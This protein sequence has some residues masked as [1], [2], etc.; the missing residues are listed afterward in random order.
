MEV[1][2]HGEQ[3]EPK[4][5]VTSSDYL[6]PNNIKVFISYSWDS[7]EHKD[8]VFFLAQALRLDGVDCVIDQF[9]QSPDNWQRWMLDQIEESDYVLIIC[10]ERYYKRYRGQEEVNKGLGVTW[11]STLI[12]GE[13]YEAQGR[14]TKFVPV[15]FSNPNLRF[16][17]DGIRNSWH[18]FSDCKPYNLLTIDDRLN[19][20]SAYESLYRL[21]TN[22]PS[23]I[24]TRLGR[25]R[26][27]E[28]IIHQYRNTAYPDAEQ[29]KMRDA[30]HTKELN[31]DQVRK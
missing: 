22:Q 7:E 2:I 30:C 8:S 16:I 13:L 29:Q 26:K 6:P 31:N 21:L 4:D 25:L 23:I 3:R 10:T 15:F 1:P 18:D 27:L 9:V 19:Y 11:E 20:P 5:S 24:P 17:P 28:P 14:N 12:M